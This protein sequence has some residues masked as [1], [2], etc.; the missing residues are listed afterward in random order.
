MGVDVDTDGFKFFAE[1]V[2]NAVFA[3]E[4]HENRLAAFE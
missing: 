4:S 1:N 3:K 2:A